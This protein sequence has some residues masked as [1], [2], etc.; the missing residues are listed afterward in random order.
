MNDRLKKLYQEVILKTAKN[1]PHFGRPET[2]DQVVE[3]RNPLCGDNYNFYPNLL[4]TSVKSISFDGFGCAISKASHALLSDILSGKSID[5]AI[6]IIEAFMTVLENPDSFSDSDLP[7]SLEAFL[8]VKEFPGRR[9]CV[10]LGWEKMR[11]Y[12]KSQQ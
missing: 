3:S 5:E 11:D 2:F 4:E 1:P 8:A 9:D 10:V 7:T 6:L 12:L